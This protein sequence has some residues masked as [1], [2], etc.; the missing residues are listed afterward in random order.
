[1]NSSSTRCQR[2]S[3]WQIDINIRSAPGSRC[4]AR[5]TA[6]PAATCGQ[7]GCMPAAACARSILCG[8]ERDAWRGRAE[9]VAHVELVEKWC[10]QDPDWAI[11]LRVVVHGTEGRRANLT[12]RGEVL[13]FQESYFFIHSLQFLVSCCINATRFEDVSPA[14]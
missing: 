13:A 4:P 3:E 10:A 12:R 7:H 14:R 5:A 1:M 9:I 2:Y 6:V 8:S 11:L